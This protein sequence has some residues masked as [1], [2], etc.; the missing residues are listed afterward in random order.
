ITTTLVNTTLA[1][2]SV[3]DVIRDVKTK[4]IEYLNISYYDDYGN[5]FEDITT[6]PFEN[7]TQDFLTIDYSNRTLTRTDLAV[8][9]EKYDGYVN[10]KYGLFR[11]SYD[12]HTKAGYKSETRSWGGDLMF[13]YPNQMWAFTLLLVAGALTF[14]AMILTATIYAF[15][16]K[17]KSRVYGI[18]V[19]YVWFT[20]CTLLLA[21]LMFP[22]S[23]ANLQTYHVG[24]W[25]PENPKSSLM[26]GES[27]NYYNSGDCSVGWSYMLVVFA[28][29]TAVFSYHTTRIA[30]DKPKG[31]LTSA[32]DTGFACEL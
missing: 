29:F 5:V 2:D 15:F 31:D 12:Y 28:F 30:L 17:D 6:N 3:A 27:A 25:N 16:V 9:Y 22:V 24:W 10:M 14:M 13:H 20:I 7:Y 1:V 21:I 11:I 8:E 23:F 19:V 26:C 4:N 32:I 18:A